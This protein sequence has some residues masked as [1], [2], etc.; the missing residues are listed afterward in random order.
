[1]KRKLLLRKLSISAPKMKVRTVLSWPLRILV[2]MT[3]L[4][5]CAA[6]MLVAYVMGRNNVAHAPTITTIDWTKLSDAEKSTRLIDQSAQAH[7]ID[8]LKTLERENVRLKED[9]AFFNNLVPGTRETSGISIQGLEVAPFAP[10]QLRFRTLVMQGR[11][12]KNR[13]SGELQLVVTAQKNNQTMYLV[14][15]DQQLATPNMFKMAFQYYQR[16]EG[17]LNLPEGVRVKH[18]QARI[19][20]NGNLRA[21]RT[22]ET[23]I[24]S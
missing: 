16:A 21:Y 18:V 1:M 3:P 6:L 23:S 2:W 20:E 19:F 22:V 5:L 12:S 9:L 11:N 8:Y 10:N 15:P 14:F 17:I 13:F 24:K 7:L 4:A